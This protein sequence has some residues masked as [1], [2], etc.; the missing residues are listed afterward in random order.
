MGNDDPTPEV[1]EPASPIEPATP[2]E[3]QGAHMGMNGHKVWEYVKDGLTLL[4]I[5]ALLW[6]IKLEVGNAQRDL[7]IAELEKDIAAL[8][9]ELDEAKDIEDGVQANALKLAE[10]TGKLD[11]ANGRLSEIT[12]L[13]RQQ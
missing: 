10:L 7:K 2:P 12:S 13:L 6:V 8:Q 9:I 1:P 11:T 4:V 3:K 5:P